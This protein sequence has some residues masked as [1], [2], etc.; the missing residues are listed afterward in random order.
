VEKAGL[1]VQEAVQKASLLK[2]RLEDT[3]EL[4][5]EV[6]FTESRQLFT[7]SRQLFTESR[8]LFTESRQLFTESRRLF[9][10]S[11]QSFTE[12]GAEGLQ[13]PQAEDR[14]PEWHHR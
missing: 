5:Q 6:L 13:R 4:R 11:R 12:S 8:Q 14:N 2:E 3:E 9:T 10:E 7:E 1:A